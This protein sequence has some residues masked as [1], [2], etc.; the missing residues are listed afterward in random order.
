MTAVALTRHADL[1]FHESSKA[2]DIMLYHRIYR[3]VVADRGIILEYWGLH[4]DELSI[5]Q[6]SSGM[7]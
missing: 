4:H 1:S 3:C 7:P 6:S 5:N 2:G